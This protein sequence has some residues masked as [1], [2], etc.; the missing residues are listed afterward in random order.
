[1]PLDPKRR[2]LWVDA[3]QQWSLEEDESGAVWL[4]AVI[5]QGFGASLADVTL[6]DRDAKR[7]RKSRAAAGKLAEKIARAKGRYP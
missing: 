1:M 4:V 3:P 5:Y 6:S 7:C 2:K